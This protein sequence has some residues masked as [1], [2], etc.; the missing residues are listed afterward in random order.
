MSNEANNK[1]KESNANIAT[2]SSDALDAATHSENTARLWDLKAPRLTQPTI[3]TYL[4][5]SSTEICVEQTLLH[6]LHVAW[7]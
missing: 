1:E 6:L 7:I 5:C 3:P 2:S 4:I